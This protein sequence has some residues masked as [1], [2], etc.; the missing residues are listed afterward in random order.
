MPTHARSAQIAALHLDLSSC[1]GLAIVQRCSRVY[2]EAYTA[3]LLSDASKLVR[4][5]R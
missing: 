3:I 2:L 1:R 4:S 5:G